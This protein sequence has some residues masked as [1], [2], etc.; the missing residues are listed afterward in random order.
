MRYNFTFFYSSSFP[1]S[2]PRNMNRNMGTL[3]SVAASVGLI[4]GSTG[5]LLYHYFFGRR[6]ILVLEQDINLLQSS[7]ANLKY[8]FEELQ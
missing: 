5:V 6:Y 2:R 7:L 1:S 4:A 3:F 8:E